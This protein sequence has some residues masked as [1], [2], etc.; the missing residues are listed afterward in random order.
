MGDDDDMM[1]SYTEDNL[2]K[3]RSDVINQRQE[4]ESTRRKPRFC[5][6]K[7]LHEKWNVA[8]IDM[9]PKLYVVN[10]TKITVRGIKEKN[11]L[12]TKKT[13]VGLTLPKLHCNDNVFCSQKSGDYDDG[14]KM[15]LRFRI[16][17]ANTDRRKTLKTGFFSKDV[18]AAPR[19]HH[20]RDD[21]HRAVNK[22]VTV[23]FK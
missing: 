12:M 11:R 6:E 21:I 19:P 5:T 14:R 22:Y 7:T 15:L 8:P 20:F 1:H 17:S 13:P 3:I 10:N 18:F 23:I 16:D 4:A 2:S 9:T